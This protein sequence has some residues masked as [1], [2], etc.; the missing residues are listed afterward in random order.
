[1]TNRDKSTESTLMRHICP[2]LVCV[3][4]TKARGTGRQRPL[5]RPMKAV[6]STLVVLLLLRCIHTTMPAVAAAHTLLL[7]ARDN[8]K[9]PTKLPNQPS[10]TTHSSPRH[11]GDSILNPPA[12]AACPHCPS[13]WLT[14]CTLGI[15]ITSRVLGKLSAFFFKLSWLSYYWPNAFH[16]SFSSCCILAE[17]SPGPA[18]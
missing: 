8:N 7:A 6:Q 12:I 16:C 4:E 5:A 11:S 1:M 9:N 13:I 2:N 17:L 18:S 3:Y 10:H 15:A 14:N